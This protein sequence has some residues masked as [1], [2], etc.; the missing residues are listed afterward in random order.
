MVAEVFQLR[1]EHF[2]S[3]LEDFVGC[4]DAIERG[5]NLLTDQLELAEE[6][7]S[8]I[9]C[10]AGHV[11]GSRLGSVVRSATISRFQLASEL[12]SVIA[13]FVC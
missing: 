1:R 3:R 2:E 11:K 12:I 13:V 4:P 9:V 7:A 10:I 5:L 8:R 6:I